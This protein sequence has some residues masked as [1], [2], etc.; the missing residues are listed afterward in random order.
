MTNAQF[1]DLLPVATRKARFAALD[2]IQKG[3]F[4]A[5]EQEDLEQEF[6]LQVWRKRERLDVSDVRHGSYLTAIIRNRG[7]DLVSHEFCER[8]DRRKLAPLPEDSDSAEIWRRLPAEMVVQPLDVNEI[9][10]L[11][12]LGTLPPAKERFAWFLREMST[13]AAARETGISTATAWRWIKEI[14]SLLE[15]RGL[16]SPRASTAARRRRGRDKRSR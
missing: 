7:R 14:E 3:Y 13:F 15:R 10:L 5:D 2:L 16:G 9:D 12:A 1:W 6:V 4:R 11:R 8:R